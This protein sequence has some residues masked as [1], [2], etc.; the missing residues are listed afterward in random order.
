LKT[1]SRI[2]GAV[3]PYLYPIATLTVVALLIELVALRVL[4]RT[5]IH[6][7]GLER[8]AM[9][10]RFVSEIGRFAFGAAFVLLFA[11]IAL[12]ALISGIR[13]RIG[14]TLV[15]S[16]FL[17]A[18]ALAAAGAVSEFALSVMT[19]AAVLAAPFLCLRVGSGP[20]SWTWASPILLAVAFTVAGL[21]SIA[22]QMA[23]DLSVPV[24]GMW[25]A[26]EALVI[27]AGIALAAHVAGPLL[28]RSM[29]FGGVAGGIVLASL[30]VQPS[31]IEILMLWNLGLAGYFHP[32][33]Y[34]AGTAVF[35]YAVHGAWILD[36]R[37]VA[38][39]AALVVA[40]GI[41]LHSTIRSAAFLMGVIILSDLTLIRSSGSHTFTRIAVSAE[42]AGPSL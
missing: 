38:I 42:D 11:L 2:G 6:I 21:P 28:G 34:A 12:V 22:Q 16:A 15:L 17:S 30:V 29:I 20:A 8:F 10:Y 19:V 36:D 33:I 7:P 14:L 27:I 13:G 25:Q 35:V 23:P 37:S 5:A 26:A 39:G 1:T 24:A 4:T 41:G 18:A 31:T 40:G 3:E 9:G 32:L